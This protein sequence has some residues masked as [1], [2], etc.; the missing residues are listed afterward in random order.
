MRLSKPLFLA[1]LAVAVLG[2]AAPASAGT[3]CFN[4]APFCDVVQFDFTV[5]PTGQVDGA[6][7]WWACPPKPGIYFLPLTAGLSSNLPGSFRVGLHG[8]HSTG[9]FGGFHSCIID[10]TITA[11][12]GFSGPALVD[13]DNGF[14]V[15]G[16]VLTPIPCPAPVQATSGP[17]LGAR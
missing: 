9:Y 11:G 4:L 7:G 14:Q 12:G 15:G 2:V 17:A 6:G 13:C 10:A 16:I 8:T 3:A 1:L 5:G